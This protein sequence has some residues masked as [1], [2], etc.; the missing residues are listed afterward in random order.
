LELN[1]Y[2]IPKVFDGRFFCFFL[3]AF[4]VLLAHG[5]KKEIYLAQEHFF[6]LFNLLDGRL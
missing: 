6:S 1:I 4:L 5:I 3:Y 2:S